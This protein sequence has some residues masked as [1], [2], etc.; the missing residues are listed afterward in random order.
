[1]TTYSER[2]E[3]AFT[4]L[5]TP[6]EADAITSLTKELAKFAPGA[7]GRELARKANELLGH[8]DVVQVIDEKWVES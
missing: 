3:R 7:T 8:G 2:L 6:S 1:M 5:A 4:G